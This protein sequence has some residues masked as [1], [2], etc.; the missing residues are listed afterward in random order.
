M[1]SV[2][3]KDDGVATLDLEGDLT[4]YVADKFNQAMNTYLEKYRHIDVDMSQVSEL[5]T[6]CYQV[7]L[8]AKLMSLQSGREMNVTSISDE[9]KQVFDL[10]NLATVFDSSEE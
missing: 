1:I 6:S 8:R 3:E 10:Y 5:D 4:I 2:T 7:L 9:A